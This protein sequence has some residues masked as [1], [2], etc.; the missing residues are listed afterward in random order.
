MT[1]ETTNSTISYTGNNSVTT[2]AYNFLTYSEDHLFIYLDDVEQTSGFSVDGVGDESGGD[3]IFNIAPGDG[4][5]IRIDRTVPETQLIEYQEYGPF[6]AKTNER[7]LDLGVMIAQQN[8]REI[9]RDSSKKMDKRTAAPENNVVIFDD[10]G[11]SKDSGATIDS[12]NVTATDRVV[13]FDTLDEAVN[14]TN[15]LKIF[16]GAAL[17]LKE[18]TAGNGGGAMWGVVL[19]S[20]VTT[21]TF[22]IV[23]CVGVPTLALAL[24][25]D[26][27]LNIK[28]LGAKGDGSDSTAV[29]QFAA[30]NYQNILVP[31]GTYLRTGKVDIL[32]GQV[33]TM[34]NPL[35]TQDGVT[36]TTVF[37][38]ADKSGWGILGRTRCEGSLVTGVDVGDENGLVIKG[39][40]KYTVENFHS[41]KMR[42]HGIHIQAGTLA[43]APRGD[44]GQ[45]N[46]CSTH[47][48]RF[49]LVVDAH[50]SAEFNIITGFTAAGNLDGIIIGAGNNSLIGGNVVDNVRGIEIIGGANHAHGIVSGMNIN[51]NGTNVKC[52]SVV[53]GHT[54]DACHA[55]GNGGTSSPIW[56]ENSKGCTYQNGVID[57]PVFNDGTVGQNGVI[58]NYMPAIAAT[59]LGTDPEFLR[60]LGNWTSSGSWIYNDEAAEYSRV[61]RGTAGQ[62]IPN[63]TVL[64]FN[65]AEKDKRSNYNT[66]TGDFTAPIAGAY[67]VRGSFTITG[68]G[69]TAAG[70]SYIELKR[71][72]TVLAFIP[73]TPVSDTVAVG[74]VSTSIQMAVGEIITMVSRVGGTSP[75]LGITT[76]RITIDTT[77]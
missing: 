31:E 50:T 68:S 7:G 19:A 34:E 15:P 65:S 49:G 26:G 30:A 23:Q 45:I 33:W 47:Q 61:S 1:V 71:D 72:A 46:F 24:R 11:N 37:E 44:Q 21:N 14:E 52:T 9:G 73:I 77:D 59:I 4:V 58:N 57:C 42:N 32:D 60:I 70:P 22:D 10:E 35:Y 54:F 55:Y 63:G 6:K 29:E 76:S 74:V 66:S 8:A 40:T 5:E 3:I 56:Y 27:A 25:V 51:H 53:N 75:I 62:A 64:V 16:N 2:F 48:S 41:H 43:P 39:C 13:P 18:R 20:S 69:F 17:N 12:I 28:T 67:D 38:A 36:F